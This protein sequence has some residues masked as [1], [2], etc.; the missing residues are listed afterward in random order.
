MNK[1]EHIAYW[2][3]SAEKDLETLH[4]LSKGKKFVQ[5]LFFGHLY[6]EKLMKAL[7]IRDNPSF[8]PPKTHNILKLLSETRVD[9]TE[10]Q[11]IFLFKLN[12]YQ[13]ESR[14]PEDIEKLYKVTNESLTK[15]YIHQIENISVCL[16]KH[17]Q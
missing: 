2:L 6:I 16:L 11:R 3:R 12:Q 15:E 5:A 13:I 7:W 17:L 14:Y 10:D 9:L 4:Y 1:E 8:F